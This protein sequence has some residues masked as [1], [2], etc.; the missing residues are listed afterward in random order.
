MNEY[1]VLTL[2]FFVGLSTLNFITLLESAICV[3]ELN[4]HIWGSLK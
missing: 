1:L 3:S 4:E 2:F